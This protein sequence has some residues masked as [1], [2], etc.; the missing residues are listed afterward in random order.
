[1]TTG[2]SLRPKIP[3]RLPEQT[4]VARSRNNDLALFPAVLRALAAH[5]TVGRLE[6]TSVGGRGGSAD[7]ALLVDLGRPQPDEREVV[8]VEETASIPGSFRLR[9]IGRSHSRST[10]CPAPADV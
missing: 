9:A 8:L 7:G 1:M 6:V 3:R 4:T 5:A 2:D 10:H